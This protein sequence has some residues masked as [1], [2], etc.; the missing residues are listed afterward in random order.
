MPIRVPADAGDQPWSAALPADVVKEMKQAKGTVHEMSKEPWW[1]ALTAYIHQ[2]QVAS[3]DESCHVQ[4]TTLAPLLR[5]HIR[6][7][8]GCPRLAEGHFP[9]AA[10]PVYNCY[11]SHPCSAAAS[12]TPRACAALQG[13]GRGQEGVGMGTATPHQPEAGR[14]GGGCRAQEAE[15]QSQRARAGAARVRLPAVR[16][17]AVPA[18]VHPLWPPLLQALP[19][20]RLCGGACLT[21]S[22][23]AD[24]KANGS[25]SL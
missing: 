22:S 1:Y 8:T 3:E 25:L 7:N 5:L 14:W 15:A 4:A 24:C 13:L 11:S 9:P 21:A 17:C 18:A 19:R 20:A 2:D 12:L 23:G 16:A 10:C 6:S